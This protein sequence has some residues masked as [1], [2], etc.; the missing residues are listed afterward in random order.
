MATATASTAPPF[1]QS[2]AYSTNIND[3]S[4]PFFDTSNGH[5]HGSSLEN[6]LTVRVQQL[7]TPRTSFSSGASSPPE[8]L[9]PGSH[10][11]A[12]NQHQH[13]HQFTYLSPSSSSTSSPSPTSTSPSAIA[14]THTHFNNYSYSHSNGHSPVAKSPLSTSHLYPLPSQ[15]A[16]RSASPALNSTLGPA[17][18]SASTHSISSSTINTSTAFNTA[19]SNGSSVYN[20]GGGISSS[21]GGRLPIQAQQYQEQRFQSQQ[22]QLYYDDE[23][24]QQKKNARSTLNGIAAFL[25]PALNQGL[26]KVVQTAQATISSSSKTSLPSSRSFSTDGGAFSTLSAAADSSS[27][28]GMLIKLYKA[29]KLPLL[30]LMWYLSSAVTNNIG[31]QIM[32]QFRY[33]VTLTFIQFVF[34]SLFCS[35]LGSGFRMTTLRKPTMGIIQM[36]APLVGFQVVGHVFSSVAISRVPLSFVHTIKVSRKDLLQG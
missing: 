5:S 2:Q 22:E 34:V 11:A 18:S 36:T 9:S 6:P 35:V 31:K 13:Q 26:S 16:L 8:N 32:N 28:R 14:S 12:F 4:I 17:L 27:T 21:L 25:P 24:E 30:C 3:D 15:P 7:P 29:S 10:S 33:P 20:V 19:Y 23:K 1:G